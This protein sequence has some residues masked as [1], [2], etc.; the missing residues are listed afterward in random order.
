MPIPDA[1]ECG[2][3]SYKSGTVC[4]RDGVSRLRLAMRWFPRFLWPSAWVGEHFKQAGSV[5]E[6]VRHRLVLVRAYDTDDMCIYGLGD[7][8]E[9]SRC[10]IVLWLTAA[11]ITSIF[12][13]PDQ[14]VF[15]AGSSG[16]ERV[17]LGNPEHP[18]I[19]SREKERRVGLALV[20]EQNCRT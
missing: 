4:S 9:S 13:P 19:A 7:G 1:A 20:A 17:C 10:L 14:V 8:C 2:S 15:C 16:S 3:C 6:I 11:P 12:I 18:P 5:P